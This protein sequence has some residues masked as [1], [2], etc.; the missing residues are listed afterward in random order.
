VAKEKIFFFL[1]GNEAK[2]KVDFTV[3]LAVMAQRWGVQV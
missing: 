2:V 3:E 1:E